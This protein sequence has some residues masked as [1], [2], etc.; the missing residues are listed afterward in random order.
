MTKKLTD[1]QKRAKAKAQ[2]KAKA[3]AEAKEQAGHEPAEKVEKTEPEPAKTKTEKTKKSNQIEKPAEK[4]GVEKNF[5][6]YMMHDSKGF[7]KLSKKVQDELREAYI[8][9]KEYRHLNPKK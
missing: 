1:A 7:R 6:W 2:A 3:D 8:K 4:H 9:D 5:V